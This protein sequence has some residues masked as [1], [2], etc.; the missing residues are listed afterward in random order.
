[1]AMKTFYININTALNR[2]EFNMI[3]SEKTSVCCKLSNVPKMQLY[4]VMK[5]GL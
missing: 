1:M 4:I 3:L 2:D 5:K